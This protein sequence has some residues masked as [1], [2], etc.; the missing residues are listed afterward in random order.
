[1]SALATDVFLPS[2]VRPARVCDLAN[3]HA[4]RADEEEL[5]ASARHTPHQAAAFGIEHSDASS[6]FLYGDLAGIFGVVP[7]PHRYGIGAPWAILTFAAELHPRPF[8]RASRAEVDHM[9]HGFYYL[10]NYVDARNVTAVRWLDWLG[11]HIEEP[12]PYG[13]DGLPFHH[14]SWGSHV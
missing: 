2:Y 8:L 1:M 9:R 6:I 11:F 4:R 7:H 10:E 3:L 13:V 14:F 12:K 5:W